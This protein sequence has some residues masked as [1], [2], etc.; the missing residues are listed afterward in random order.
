VPALAVTD[1]RGGG[2]KADEQQAG[3]GLS[4]GL[5][6]VEYRLSLCVEAGA[7]CRTTASAAGYGQY[8]RNE[9]CAQRA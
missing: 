4:V 1:R 3:G 8:W 7:S 2:Q 5:Q 9:F 6:T